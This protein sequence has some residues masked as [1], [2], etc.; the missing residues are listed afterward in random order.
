MGGREEVV[1]VWGRRRERQ[2]DALMH[3]HA[4]RVGSG[5][6][7]CLPA[8]RITD[9]T[10]SLPPSPTRQIFAE[11][12]PGF[13]AGS[14]D[15]AYLDVTDCCAERGWTGAQVA[16]RIRARVRQETGLTCRCARGRC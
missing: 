8:R 3:R 7:P 13:E 5:H 6:L 15:E 12:D 10:H 14:L 9:H 11:F 4:C 2:G 16:E 1:V